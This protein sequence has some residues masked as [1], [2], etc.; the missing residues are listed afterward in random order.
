M[1]VSN[2]SADHMPTPWFHEPAERGRLCVVRHKSHPGGNGEVIARN[3][4]L[5][6][7]LF[8]VKACNAYVSDQRIIAEL[9]RAL[10]DLLHD[11][12]TTYAVRAM[13]AEYILAVPVV[14]S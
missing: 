14:S 1:D 2:V 5:R 10:D 6:D 3:V 4:E 8:I 11:K 9:R 13:R 7:A 12:S